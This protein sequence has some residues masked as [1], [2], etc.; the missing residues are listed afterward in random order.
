M[1]DI[2]THTIVGPDGTR[3]D[4]VAGG[5]APPP[6]KWKRLSDAAWDAIVDAA[7]ALDEEQDA[8]E[9]HFKYKMQSGPMNFDGSPFQPEKVDPKLKYSREYVRDEDGK[10]STTGY[11]GSNKSFD[12]FDMKETSGIFGPALYLGAEADRETVQQWAEHVASKHGGNPTV[13]KF[14]V[15]L[16]K[17]FVFEADGEREGLP[18]WYL[19]IIDNDAS[20][21]EQGAQI[22]EKALSL[23][24]DGVVSLVDG[25]VSQMAIYDLGKVKKY[26]AFQE[27]DHPR[28][29]AGKF[30]DKSDAHGTG[31]SHK[32]M[33]D[34]IAKEKKESEWFDTYMK[35][36][37]GEIPEPDDPSYQGHPG[38]AFEASEAD[39]NVPEV[40]VEFKKTGETAKIR[41]DALPFFNKASAN[42]CKGPAGTPCIDINTQLPDWTR[43]YFKNVNAPVAFSIMEY[44]SS[45]FKEVNSV[46]RWGKDKLK[47]RLEF[48]VTN[49][50][51]TTKS[52]ITHIYN[53]HRAFLAAK[54]SKEP[55]T[56]YRG[57][58]G[59][60]S[61][62]VTAKLKAQFMQAYQTGQPFVMKGFVSASSSKDWIDKNKSYRIVMEIKA[63]KGLDVRPL[64]NLRNENEFLM[65]HGTKFRITDHEVLPDGRDKFYMEQLV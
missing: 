36:H 42:N 60:Y 53:L 62:E 57:E 35:E 33:L 15:G 41:A 37:E 39:Q 1:D 10:F 7:F 34:M 32:A 47:D 28:D 31:I 14:G 13:S 61:D 40:P 55:V 63:R 27:K 48:D 20:P 49:V 46:L 45:V 38:E 19:D 22:K 23:G 64:S 9:P 21:K 51:K 29:D 24:Y 26:A 6:R 17:P 18:K 11:H 30:T 12:Q 25:K 65:K 58:H 44:T 3:Y 4:C 2:F 52:S 54:V 5:Q 56:V 59:Q 16:T 43:S 8:K 50:E